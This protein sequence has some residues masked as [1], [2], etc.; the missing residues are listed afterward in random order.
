MGQKSDLILHRRIHTGEKPYECNI[1][2]KKFSQLGHLKS[3][4]KIH[5]GHNEKNF[6][7]DACFKQFA[8]KSSLSVHLKIHTGEKN[9]ICNICNKSFTQKSNLEQHLR[10]HTGEKQHSCDKCG[11]SYV[12]PSGLWNHKKKCNVQSSSHQSVTASTSD[13]QFID[14]DET[15]KQEIKEEIETN[16]DINPYEFVKSELCED[17]IESGESEA[18]CKET[19]KLEI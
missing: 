5:H 19:I 1:C 12:A 18:D 7:C 9:Y 2:G 10:V 8:N 13:I 11:K 17:T 16:V 14:C 15:I 4:D 3:H 6:K